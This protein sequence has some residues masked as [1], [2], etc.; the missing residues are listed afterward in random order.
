MSII[1]SEKLI[2]STYS[3]PSVDNT[4]DIV[5]QYRRVMRYPDDASSTKV[6]HDLDLPRG[7]VRPWL[8][9]KKPDAVHAIDTARE[10]GW[11]ADE[12][13]PVTR[14]FS[15]LV[16]SL[17]ATGTIREHGWVPSW[18]PKEIITRQQIRSDL[19]TIG[20]GWQHAHSES[21]HQTTEI[22]P[23]KHSSI[24]GRSLAVAGAPVG[25]KHDSVV[26]LPAYLNGAPL[27]VRAEFAEWYIRER[28][29]QFENKATRRIQVDRP[30]GFYRQIKELVEDVTGESVTQSE[31]GLTISAA[32]VRTLDLA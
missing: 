24:L 17:F 8:D 19:N 18:T 10:L 6:A 14:A 12:W 31:T 32:A 28:G 23:K 26:D 22:R 11:L 1:N 21:E 5:E 9:D 25:K 4:Y 30:A 16:A 2:V 20:T 27:S 13:T 7:R 3:H 29:I 15:R